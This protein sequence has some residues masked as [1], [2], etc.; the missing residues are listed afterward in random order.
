MSV[1][2]SP[3]KLPDVDPDEF[4]STTITASGANGSIS[5]TNTDIIAISSN[6]LN[7]L[8]ANGTT[9]CTANGAY[10]SP[11]RNVFKYVKTDLSDKSDIPK[12]AVGRSVLPANQEF[13][14]LDQDP[15]QSI[16]KEYQVIVRFTNSANALNT[17]SNTITSDVDQ[18]VKNDYNT[19]YN[20]VKDYYAGRN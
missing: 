11:F 17:F 15:R 9:S 2:I 20:F 3:T 5:I 18:I 8:L 7:V 12:L 13:Y 1:T 16:T 10:L 4:F 14:N 19:I 6:T